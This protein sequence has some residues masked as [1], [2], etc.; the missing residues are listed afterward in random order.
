MSSIQ[1]AT[2]VDTANGEV[3]FCHDPNY[4]YAAKI[5]KVG[6]NVIFQR[7]NLPELLKLIPVIK[8]YF[9]A[10]FTNS[11]LYLFDVYFNEEGKIMLRYPFNKS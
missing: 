7:F 3:L 11:K 10:L 8:N 1:T 2:I 5:S 9:I 6:G 4:L